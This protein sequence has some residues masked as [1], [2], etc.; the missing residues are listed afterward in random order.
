MITWAKSFHVC[1]RQL[2]KHH[3]LKLPFLDLVGEISVPLG[4]KMF[5]MAQ[6]IQHQEAA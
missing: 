4:Y 2:M 1:M 3:N 5:V 6:N